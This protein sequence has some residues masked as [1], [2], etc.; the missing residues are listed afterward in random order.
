MSCAA[1][2]PH[3]GAIRPGRAGWPSPIRTPWVRRGEITRHKISTGQ[4]QLVKVSAVIVEG[5]AS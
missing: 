4:P 1:K 2:T 5:S 3:V